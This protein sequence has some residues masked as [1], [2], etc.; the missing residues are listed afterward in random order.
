MAPE[1]S[2]SV[3]SG[4]C[5]SGC[6]ANAMSQIV[7]YWKW[8]RHGEGSHA[9]VLDGDDDNNLFHLNWGWAGWGNGYYAIDGFYLTYYSF[10]WFH[11]AVFDIHPNE[12]YY[13]H[14][15]PVENLNAYVNFFEFAGIEFAPIYETLNVETLYLID[16][17]VV[18]RDN[19]AIERL[20]NVTDQ[21]VFIEMD[22]LPGEGTYCYAMCAKNGDVMSHVVRDTLVLNISLTFMMSMTMAGICRQWLSW[23]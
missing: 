6:V 18:M 16:T 4:H 15:K 5:K 3:F 21:H 13:N 10:P 17:I 9:Y 19:M 14:S 22:E 8:P 23:M 20:A 1:D 12:E 2:L 7:R 11:N